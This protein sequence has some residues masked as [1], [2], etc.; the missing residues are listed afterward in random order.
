MREL[1]PEYYSDTEDRVAYVLDAP[2][3]E[4]HLETITQH[5]QTHDFELFCR[6]L[7][8]RT[9]C[10]N[11]R[12]QTGPEGGGDGKVD[13]ETYPV[14]EEIAALR[15]VGEANGGKERWAFAF[16]AN[17]GWAD[18]ARADVKGI[19]ET[20]RKYD[21]IICVTSRAARSKD[22]LRVEKEL[23][24]QYSI[25]VV[26]HDR[27]WITKEIIEN[28]RK[29]LAFNYLKV[30]EAKNDPLRLGPNDY[31][32]TQQ[33][34][35]IEKG[36]E[37][38]EAFK[39]MAGQRVTE[40]LIVAKL[41]RNL[42]GSISLNAEGPQV[43]TTTILGMTIE[44]K[45]EGSIQSILVAEAVLSSLEAFF[46]TALEQQISP[47]TEKLCINL[48]ERDDVS[49]PAFEIR[50]LDMIGTLTWPTS[51]S[52]TSYGQQGDIQKFLMAVSGDVLAKTCLLGNVDTVLQRLFVDEAVQNRMMM[53]GV[54][55]NSYHRVAS[56]Y[57]SRMSDWQ[58]AVKNSYPLRTPRPKLTL[59][60]LEGKDSTGPDGKGN[61]SDE[62]PKVKDHRELSIRSVIDVHAWDQAGWKGT[63][64]AQFRPSE[65]PC[66]A[67][68]FE[69]EEGARKIFERWK[70]RFGAI[71]EN[72]EI[73]LS[74]I[75]QLSQENKHH[76]CFLITSKPSALTTLGANQ[77]LTMTTRS[78]VMAPS[79]DVNL[80]QFLAS[81]HRSGK[82]YLMPA[83]LGR[84]NNPKFLHDLA[85]L[86]Q[87]ISIKLAE[88]VGKHEI[89]SVALRIK[90]NA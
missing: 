11:L 70:E 29:D 24:E 73:Y 38:P 47:H 30:G 71:D 62:P 42:Q 84:Q 67:F 55:A 52:P 13:S 68:L 16:S 21:R 65:P 19:V 88:D 36:I 83:V 15:Y 72:E 41:S 46:A 3:F 20:G 77:K 76:Y 53:V 49:E 45:F 9:I 86:K 26:I 85:I 6:K 63:A 58:D 80:E 57:I 78:M 66:I 22:R 27:S 12:P 4:H 75:R 10:P 56:R 7:C 48:V 79:S 37:D 64:Y 2:V 8:E 61:R 51:L 25:P 1:R 35:E 90:R 89:E 54:A 28:D 18:K 82:F 23:S 60:E 40:A 33:I 34:A 32:R 69:N 81:Y 17:K 50:A 43:L 87:D 31:S 44:V 5:N 39:G 59:T 14:S 74:I